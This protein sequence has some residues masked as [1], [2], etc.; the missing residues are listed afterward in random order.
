MWLLVITAAELCAFAPFATIPAETSLHPNDEQLLTQSATGQ[1]QGT[2]EHI[3]LEYQTMKEITEVISG[4]N[5]SDVLIHQDQQFDRMMLD[6]DH[7]RLGLNVSCLAA[8]NCTSLNRQSCEATADTCG[9]CIHGYFG[10]Y[11]DSNDLC[12]IID[13]TR[14]PSCA[15]LNRYTHPPYFTCHCEN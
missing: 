11:G 1:Y 13:C 3:A 14:A 4:V 8:P 6:R 12:G 10:T 15:D 2:E 9:T 7:A 5:V